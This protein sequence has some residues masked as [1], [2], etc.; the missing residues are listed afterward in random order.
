[1][2]SL[3][4]YLPW[5][6]SP[7]RRRARDDQS[8]ETVGWHWHPKKHTERNWYVSKYFLIESALIE[9]KWGTINEL[10]YKSKTLAKKLRSYCIISPSQ[11]WTN[12]VLNQY[13][14]SRAD[15]RRSCRERYLVSFWS[16]ISCTYT[17]ENSLSN[18]VMLLSID[19][20]KDINKP[21]AL[22]WTHVTASQLKRRVN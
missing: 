21:T 17:L 7:W 9:E 6:Y 3:Y 11:E 13:H 18:S 10:Y 15:N 1:M 22:T 12:N 8:W 4:D 20:L 16:L 2:A 19:E 14:Y 5:S